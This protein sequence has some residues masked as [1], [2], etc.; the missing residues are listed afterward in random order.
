MSS[1]AIQLYNETIL[2]LSYL[3]VELIEEW[4]NKKENG[5]WVGM[6]IHVMK[7]WVQSSDP[8][9]VLTNMMSHSLQDYALSKLSGIGGNPEG[10]AKHMISVSGMF[11]GSYE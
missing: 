7:L 9:I 2:T 6:D 5:K 1:P 4:I 3:S 10:G 11:D 8:Q